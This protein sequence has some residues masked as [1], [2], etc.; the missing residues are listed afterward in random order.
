MTSR[1]PADSA[2]LNLES[3]LR[4]IL[5]QPFPRFSDAE[6]A[7]RRVALGALMHKHE[8]DQLLVCGEQRAGTGVSWVTGWVTTTEQIVV[9]DPRERPKM[10]VEWVNHAPLAKQIAWDCD[11]EWSEHRS[12]DKV[13]AELKR[14]AARRIGIIGVFN[15]GKYR[16]LAS[17][18]PDIVD[19][20]AEYGRLRLTK[21]AEELDWLRIGA[22]FCDASIGALREQLAPGLN[23]RELGDIVER[24]YVPFGGTTFLHY[25]GVTA[26]ADPDCFV[27]RQHPMNRIV[28][29]GDC[30]F[31]EITGAFWDYGGQVLRTFAVGAEPTALYRDLFDTA[32]A[33]YDAVTR[34]MR[35]RCTMAEIVDATSVIEE[36]GFTIC[37]DLVHGFGGG[38]FPPILGTRSRPAGPLPDFVLAENMTMVVQPNVI[39]RARPAGVQVGELVRITATG[40]ESLHR[41]PRGFFRVG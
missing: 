19:L 10:F 29:A 28:R 24:A 7:R 6:I 40:C 25:F 30:V 41:S 12:V 26:M 9:V 3:R 34:V 37:D 31:T 23:E 15:F 8:V 35:P 21:S 32:E 13:I 17:S 18:F 14:R 33:A 4:A 22:A 36:R 38:Y 39:D 2:C 11:V 20:N 16:K 27:P 1:I 5:E